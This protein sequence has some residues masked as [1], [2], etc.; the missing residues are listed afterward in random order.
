[1]P[2]AAI[3][4]VIGR[5]VA[6]NGVGEATRSSRIPSRRCR[7]NAAAAAVVVS[8]QMPIIA[9]PDRRRDERR[10]LLAT[11]EEEVRHRRVDQRRADDDVEEERVARLLLEVQLPAERHRAQQLAHARSAGP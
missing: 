10:L 6:Q 1:M 11:L 4:S 7:C 3:A 8:D 9:E 5:N 2:I